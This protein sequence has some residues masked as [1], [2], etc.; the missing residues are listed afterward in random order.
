M[1]LIIFVLFSCFEDEW[2]TDDEQHGVR[3][4]AKLVQVHSG[5]DRHDAAVYTR[6]ERGKAIDIECI[7]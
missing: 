7:Q 5:T 4:P 6:S 1:Y 3:V 2:L